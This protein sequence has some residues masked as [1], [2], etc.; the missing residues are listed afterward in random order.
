MFQLIVAVISIFLVAALVL[1]AVY[2]GGSS[3]SEAAI[4]AQYAGNMNAAAQIE[5][6]MQL[7]Y[8]DHA[9]YAP[10]QDA[11]LLQF[12]LEKNYLKEIPDGDWKV[13]KD[14]LYKPFPAEAQDISVCRT[15]NKVAGFDITIP[16]IAAAPYE[17]CPPC[18]GATGSAELA[19]AERYKSW[20]GCQFVAVD[21]T[22]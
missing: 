5:G 14:T 20:P 11:T 7:Y 9:T 18:N 13:S 16:E 19:L 2:Y 8:N 4:K 22:P 6:A 12:L 3:H 10:G 21:E 15:M 17:G 1:A